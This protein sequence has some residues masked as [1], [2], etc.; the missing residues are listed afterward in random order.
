MQYHVQPR[1]AYR[2]AAEMLHGTF[3]CAGAGSAGFGGAPKS[4]TPA[5]GLELGGA[6]AAALPAPASFASAGF[7]AS[8]EAKPPPPRRALM[9]LL[10]FSTSS[11]AL[12]NC[13]GSSGCRRCNTVT[14][15]TRA[16]EA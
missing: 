6:G 10:V 11:E 9:I 1:H 3:G 15:C 4:E 14:S 5:K 2:L 13:P 12:A 8:V 16:G 7:E